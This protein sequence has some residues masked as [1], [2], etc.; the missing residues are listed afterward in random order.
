[1]SR[2][3]LPASTLQSSLAGHLVPDAVLAHDTCAQFLNDFEMPA[4][5]VS[6]LI[7]AKKNRQ[8][9]VAHCKAAQVLVDFEV[10]N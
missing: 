6:N 9:G 5:V 8:L 1:M 7:A 10:E 3:K 2:K 4:G